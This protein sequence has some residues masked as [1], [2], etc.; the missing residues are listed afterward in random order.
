MARP[1]LNCENLKAVDEPQRLLH[2]VIFL[3]QETLRAI[4][5]HELSENPAWG[6]FYLHVPCPQYQDISPAAR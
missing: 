3:R 6:L 1:R 2:E 4:S 5:A